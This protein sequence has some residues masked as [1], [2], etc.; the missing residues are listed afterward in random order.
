MEAAC[1]TEAAALQYRY[2]EMVDSIFM[3]QGRLEDPHL[4]QRAIDLGLDLER[5]EE[6]RRS[7]AVTE[8]VRGDF[9]S[10]IRVG[11]ATTPSI[12]VAGQLSQGVPDPDQIS[13]WIA[14]QDG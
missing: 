1:A 5:F 8:R 10:A 2:W 14:G 3:D 11:V 7:D 13:A 6:D 12:L 9:R 4:W